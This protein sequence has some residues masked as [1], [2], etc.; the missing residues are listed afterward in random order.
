MTVYTYP[1][2]TPS[3]LLYRGT[4]GGLFWNTKMAYAVMEPPKYIDASRIK[5]VLKYEELLPVIEEA[6]VNFS[7]RESGGIVQ[8]IRSAVQME[9]RG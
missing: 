5:E 8:P 1:R 6:L 3:I 2:S 7:A 4:G 9:D